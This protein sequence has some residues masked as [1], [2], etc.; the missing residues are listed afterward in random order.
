MCGRL[1]QACRFL[2]VR[3]RTQARVPTDRHG[4][5][6]AAAN[7]GDCHVA[8][9]WKSTVPGNS[10]LVLGILGKE[11]G[12]QSLGIRGLGE[13]G[14]CSGHPRS[15]SARSFQWSST[16]VCWWWVFR[17][18]MRIPTVGIRIG[19]CPPLVSCLWLARHW[20]WILKLMD[21]EIFGGHGLKGVPS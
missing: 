17:F 12:L 7:R 14:W 1:S 13:E 4:T 21:F 8:N 16:K 9:G 18:R 2:L 10:N 6:L 5:V 15:T 20:W 19:R 11:K 3:S